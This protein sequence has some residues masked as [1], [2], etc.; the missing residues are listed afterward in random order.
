MRGRASGSRSC[1]NRAA[2]WIEFEGGDVSYPIWVGC[3]WRD[4]EIPQEA[5]ADVKTIIS[6]SV[7]LVLDDGQTTSSWSDGNQ[8][9]ITLDSNGIA[10]ERQSQSV[11]IQS[12]VSVNGGA[13]EVQ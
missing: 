3:Y 2:A 9:T 6:Q 12:T 10:A 1:R 5:K 8:N 4:G 13:L 7:K 11:K